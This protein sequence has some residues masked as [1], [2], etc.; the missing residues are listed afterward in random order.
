MTQH[1][2]IKMAIAH[3]QGG[4]ECNLS[5]NGAGARVEM[6]SPAFGRA[7]ASMDK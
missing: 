5:P 3:F 6:Q 7:I 2:T 1:K 4:D